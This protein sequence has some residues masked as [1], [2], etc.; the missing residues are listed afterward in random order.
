MCHNCITI[1]LQAE[2]TAKRI[3]AMPEKEREAYLLKEA[4][5]LKRLHDV[6]KKWIK[7]NQPA[8]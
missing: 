3:A 6:R 4:E 5:S 7:D 1:K 8:D 2:E